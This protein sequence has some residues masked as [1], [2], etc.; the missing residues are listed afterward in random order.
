M[1]FSHIADCHLGSWREPKM[2]ELNLNSFKQAIEISIKEKVDFILIGGDLFDTAIPSIEIIASCAENLK[3]LK[4]QQIPCYIIPGSHDFSASGKTM[5]TVL[6]KAGLCINISYNL[7]NLNKLSEKVFFDKP[8]FLSGLAGKKLG[9]EQQDLLEFNGEVNESKF[10]I[11][12]LHTTIKEILPESMLNQVEKGNINAISA[13]EILKNEK[14][15]KFNYF[16][17][18]HIHNPLIKEIKGE[19]FAYPGALFPNNFSELV[20]NKRGNFLIVNFNEGE[21]TKISDIREIPI[22]TK[23]VQFIDVR[24]DGLN[25]ISLRE[26]IFSEA[27]NLDLENKIVAIKIQGIMENGKISDISFDEIE[28]YFESRNIYCLLRNISKLESKE[29]EMQIDESEGKTM[30]E[31]ESHVINSALEQK[32][33]S[34]DEKERLTVLMKTMDTEKIE[35]ETND[36]FATRITN[37][38]V[39]ILDLKE[40]WS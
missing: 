30:E 8:Y 15:K 9:L 34:L 26:K 39:A 25:P 12:G 10:N 20:E 16:A 33:I 21:D 28:T 11:L 32:A 22:E 6:E 19:V 40:I 37:D 35:G 1:K 24:A 17:L 3:E 4:E 18:G 13:E 2:Q 36:T 29:F 14:L 38:L 7:S 23:K 5:I 31:I 27:K